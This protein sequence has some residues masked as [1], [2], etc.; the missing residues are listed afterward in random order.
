MLPYLMRSSVVGVKSGTESGITRAD[1][2]LFK[3]S[4]ERATVMPDDGHVCLSA[5]RGEA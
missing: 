1:L 4:V 5:S 3:T 2:N